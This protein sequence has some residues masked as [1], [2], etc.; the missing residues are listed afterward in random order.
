M[1]SLTEGASIRHSGIDQWSTL[2]AVTAM[3]EGQLAAVASLQNA[4][5][6][7]AGAAEHAAERLSGGGRLVYVGAGTSGRLAV[8]DGVELGPTFGWPLERLRFCLAG[9][10]GALTE[11]AE[12]AEDDTEAPIH[13]LG[14]IDLNETD[15]V[16]GVAASGT[17]PFTV[18]ALRH[19][20]LKGAFTIGIANNADGPVT[21]A[22][23]HA[24]V[25]VTG[26]ELVAGSTR[27]KAGTAQKAV[28]N[29]LSTA[30]MM[31]LGKVYR[32]LMV[33]MVVSNDKLLN[34]A[35][36]MVSELA[37]VSRE[38]AEV[39]LA[40]SD[41]DI[42]TAILVSLGVSKDASMLMLEEHRGDLRA[43]LHALDES[44][45]GE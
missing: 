21:D 29:L 1:P 24:I 32:G 27:M 38:V 20:K 44:D 25:V 16:I 5:E 10:L 41:F 14:E 36:R 42:K 2:D 45:L 22:A 40:L 11:S 3:Y 39:S 8:L 35:I 6:S 13:Q 18:A 15:V 33:D 37:E 17:T 30:I 31:R 12:G 34:R 28:L 43:A 4:L 9:G 26:S 23:H 19:A 7:I